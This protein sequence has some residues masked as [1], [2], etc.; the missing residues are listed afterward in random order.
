MVEGIVW[1]VPIEISLSD[2]FIWMEF[3]VQK[4]QSFVAIS[5]VKLRINQY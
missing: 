4:F 1:K 2:G 5:F 3:M